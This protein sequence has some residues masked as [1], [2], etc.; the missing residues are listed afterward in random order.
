MHYTILYIKTK[1]EL[2]TLLIYVCKLQVL[3]I[4]SFQN[5]SSL[6]IQKYREQKPEFQDDKLRGTIA[7]L[8]QKVHQL[9]FYSQYQHPVQHINKNLNKVNYK[10]LIHYK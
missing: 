3:E 5:S 6:D 1:D 10:I 8:S 4:V 7:D 2:Y 9:R